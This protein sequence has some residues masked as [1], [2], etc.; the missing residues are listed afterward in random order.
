MKKILEQSGLIYLMQKIKQYFIKKPAIQG[1]SGQ[2]LALDN[3]GNTIWSSLP[4]MLSYKGTKTLLSEVTS[5]TDCSVGDVWYVSDNSSEYVCI[6]VNVDTTGVWE[7]LGPHTQSDWTQSDS[8]ALDYIK[9][10]PNLMP[11][12]INVGTFLRSK[13]AL[14]N[15]SWIE[16]VTQDEFKEKTFYSVSH[17]LPHSTSGTSRQVVFE[18][19]PQNF[20]GDTILTFKIYLQGQGTS[21]S[22]TSLWSRYFCNMTIIMYYDYQNTDWTIHGI[23]NNYS[24]TIENQHSSNSFTA[25][26]DSTTKKVSFS[27]L[28][29]CLSDTFTYLILSNVET[30][31]SYTSKDIQENAINYKTQQNTIVNSTSSIIWQKTELFHTDITELQV[32]YCDAICT[33]HGILNVSDNMLTNSSYAIANTSPDFI[34]FDLSS[35]TNFT[36]N[37]GYAYDTNP[38]NKNI[39]IINNNSVPITVNI[40]VSSGAILRNFYGSSNTVTIPVNKS[41]ECIITFWRYGAYSWNGGLEA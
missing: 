9:N 33:T 5:L 15:Y 12:P 10:K 31:G 14:G 35:T 21:L 7:Q 34:R 20:T 19:N 27:W 18:V 6:S 16:G 24:N 1:Q 41:F 23:L 22:N 29:N 8:G 40:S 38:T 13:D 32:N 11:E 36:L 17:T 37:I 2:V 26:V 28:G 25:L 4:T 39:I 3:D 30:T